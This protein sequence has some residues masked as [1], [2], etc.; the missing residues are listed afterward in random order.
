MLPVA[1]IFPQLVELFRQHNN[2]ILQ[3]PPGAG[4][5]TWLPLA[6]IKQNCISGKI[7]LLEP[8]RVA[9]RNIAYFLAEKMGE[10]LG[11]T[12]GLR[13]RGESVTSQHTRL[14]VVTEGVMTRILQ[15]DPELADVGLIIFDE[16]HERSLQ[17]DLAFALAF[18]VQS[19]LRDDLKLLVMSATLDK[20]MLSR[21]LPDAPVLESDG[22]LHPV[23]T[24]YR[25]VNQQ[26]A[27]EQQ[28]LKVCTEALNHAGD[29]LI[30]F[31]G[32]KEINRAKRTLSAQLDPN[33]VLLELHGSLPIQ[34][35]AAALKP[36]PNGKR[37]ILLSTNIAE[38]S[39]TVQ[40][41]CIVIDCGWQKR[42]KFDDKTGFT[43]LSNERISQAS[44]EQRRGRAGR[45]QAGICYRLW[46]E[47]EHSRLR[48]EYPAEIEQADISPLLMEA[49][50]WGVA[51]LAE[52]NLPSQPS[53][54]ASQRAI[55]RLQQLNLVDSNGKQTE[56][57]RKV[58]AS[59]LP[60]QAAILLN[61]PEYHH[62]PELA[63]WLAAWLADGC[64]HQAGKEWRV[65][66]QLASVMHGQ[67]RS[68]VTKL[69]NKNAKLNSKQIEL[70]DSEM[71]TL[72]V[73]VMPERIA[74]RRASS[75]QFLMASGTAV[76][77]APDV[78][79]LALPDF[80]L[81]LEA[82]FSDRGGIIRS[83]LTMEKP[84]LYQLAERF[85]EKSV[86]ATFSKKGELKF[87]ESERLM[88]LNLDQQALTTKPSAAQKT[89][90]WLSYIQKHGFTE[91][92]GYAHFKQT[93]AR[94]NMAKQLGNLI[95]V[96]ADEQSCAQSAQDWLALF[97]GSVQG[98][99]QLLKVDLSQALMSQLDYA[100]QQWLAT[101]LPTQYSL[102]DGRT[103]TIDYLN[104]SGPQISVY[105]QSLYSLSEHPSL[106]QGKIKLNLDLISPA[107]RTIQTTADLPA[108]WQGSY[109]L[110]QKE[111]KSQ[112][113]KHF[114]P[115]NP[116][117]AQPGT[118]T[119]RQ[120]KD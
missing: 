78:A 49:L 120:R 53:K 86:E 34:A 48:A 87:V 103:A 3:A 43:Q 40:G 71:L 38:T 105:M 106:A 37:K 98:L 108:F 95:D 36:D 89:K 27:F 69:S 30:F 26:T 110:V 64:R 91:F 16:F 39:L 32:A 92:A 81:V 75:E 13:M 80:L 104:Q 118:K 63:C 82:S 28:L 68:Q 54:V 77:F 66:R 18:D 115:D 112:Y 76:R 84:Q 113:P 114:W 35:Q 25:P 74:Q 33:V 21:I 70:M 9:A 107:R 67:L 47:E 22:R 102:P 15:S 19:A 41:V 57:G 17:A 12:V 52:L 50:Q 61:Q 101:Q 11:Q 111:M 5:S 60:L 42:A 6:L 8:R 46:R 79:V 51:D 90:A 7:I 83:A 2:L 99:Q 23:T 73:A 117:A 45:L 96:A 62:Q 4:K 88:A 29:I 44:A 93:L 56:L 10:K 100:A 24:Y 85:I 97:L 59:G 14:E 65:E 72:L 31:S 119:K 109:K 94:L 55:T 20:A 58:A 116:A 1:E